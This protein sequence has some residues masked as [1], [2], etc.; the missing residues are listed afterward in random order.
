MEKEQ[1]IEKTNDSLEKKLEECEKIR[2]EY[3][4]GWQRARA[5]FLNYKKEELERLERMKDL[6]RIEL[7]T[8]I[9]KILDDFERAEKEIPSEAEDSSWVSGIIQIKGRLR[10]FLQDEGAEEMKI[11]KG[12][13]FNPNFHE[14]VD[15]IEMDSRE[16]GQIIEVLEKGYLIN[17]QLLRP[18]KVKLAK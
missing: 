1:N 2:E 11:K 4:A 18:A 12:E 7:V 15:E 10:K 3:L 5:D 17:G 14:A 8:K 13:K 6:E 9:L 16:S